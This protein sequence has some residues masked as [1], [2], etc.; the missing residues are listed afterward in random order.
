MT[1]TMPMPIAA[2]SRDTEADAKR[3]KWLERVE[4]GLTQASP[5]AVARRFNLHPGE[6]RDL[7]PD[8]F[9]EAPEPERNEISGY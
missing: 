7:F 3:A 5:R 1:S 9:D 8:Y 4:A 2:K 6:L